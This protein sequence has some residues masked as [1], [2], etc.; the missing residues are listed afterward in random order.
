M[1]LLEELKRRNVFR[2]GI[3]YA[4]AGWLVL[5]LTDVLSEL[6]DLPGTIGPIVVTFVAIGFPIALIVAWAYELTPDG[7]KRESE[8][9]RTASV[10]RQTGRTLDRTIIAMLAMVAGYFIWESR[11][12]GIDENNQPTSGETAVAGSQ[13]DATAVESVA[14]ETATRQGPE[15]NQDQAI[16]PRSIAVLPF[17]NRSRL[18]DDAF[19]V[20]GIHDDLLTNLARIGGLKVISRT[21]VARYT[22]TTTPIPEIAAELGVATVME[23]AVQRSGDMVRINVQLIDAETDEHVWAQIFDRTLTADNLFAIQSEISG[24]IAGA[25]KTELTDDETARLVERPTENLEAYTAYLRGRQLLVNRRSEELNQA[26][27]EFQRAT[28]LDP[29]FA[30]AWVGVAD[31]AGLASSYG[32]LE[33]ADS[34]ALQKVATERALSLDPDLGEAHLAN[35]ALMASQGLEA[36]AQYERAI[37]L[38]PGNAVGYHWYATYL[39][40]VPANL[41]RAEALLERALEIDP[42]SSIIRSALVRNLAQQGQLAQ[43]QREL[44]RLFELDPNFVLAFSVQADL[45]FRRGRFDEQIAWLRRAAAQDPDSFGPYFQMIWTFLD[46]EDLEAIDRLRE[47]MLTRVDEDHLNIAWLDAMRTMGAGNP[48]ASL[49]HMAWIYER[50]GRPPSIKAIEGYLYTQKGDPGRARAA[51]EVYDPRYF[52]PERWADAIVDRPEDACMA[53]WMLLGTG[54]EAEG[55]ALLGETVRYLKEELPRYVDDAH[56]YG[57]EYCY[58]VQGDIPAALAIVEQRWTNRNLGRWHF[59]NRFPYFEPMLREP[60]YQE[61]NEQRLALVAEQSAAIARQPLAE[62]N[63]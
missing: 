6:L 58:M 23:G 11:F 16:D 28:T 46:L 27:T 49:E 47:H 55:R 18:E 9:D 40:D 53:G 8:V 41:P 1:R 24:Q 29:D 21:S 34:I 13:S 7:V 54:E 5:Q 61:I 4:V 43:A 3:A 39:D 52:D 22:D 51:F 38:S 10:T 25:L 15:A 26:L 60:Q 32:T 59:Y 48:D 56:N 57:L 63:P 14:A 17:N 20:E 30:L 42:L 2:V 37:E 19:F 12:S 50:M 33:F 44:D 62:V 45:N 31:A 35:A 36:D